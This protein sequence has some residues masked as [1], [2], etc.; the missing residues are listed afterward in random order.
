[1][2]ITRTKLEFIYKFVDLI[3]SDY[4]Q[5]CA[6][7]RHSKDAEGYN[8]CFNAQIKKKQFYYVY[9]S[10]SLLFLILINY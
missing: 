8:N 5:V 6:K 7:T 3:I 4:F 2:K 10:S 9:S 1:V